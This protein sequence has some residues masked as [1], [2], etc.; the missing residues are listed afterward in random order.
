MKFYFLFSYWILIWFILQQFDIISFNPFFAFL[1][2]TCFD[3]LMYI[4]KNALNSHNSHSVQI[5]K[6]YL[7]LLIHYFPYLFLQFNISFEDITF[8]FLLFMVYMYLLHKKSLTL[9]EIYFFPDNYQTILSFIDT[10]FLK[11]FI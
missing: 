1:C 5:F 11:I 8:T 4:F 3:F 9:K 2:I 7:V 10:R 6:F